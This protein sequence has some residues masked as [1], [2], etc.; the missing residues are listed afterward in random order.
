MTH[1]N[2]PWQITKFAYYTHQIL[3]D[4]IFFSSEDEV[5][6][7]VCGQNLSS[8]SGIQ[9]TLGMQALVLQ[10]HFGRTSW[11]P[12]VLDRYEDKLPSSDFQE[13]TLAHVTCARF[14]V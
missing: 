4:G 9:W 7:G 1:V 2:R 11:I 6:A 12:L 13:S 5:W 10:R 3:K 8:K 14:N